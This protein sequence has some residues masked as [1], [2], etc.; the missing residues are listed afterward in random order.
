[1]FNFFIEEGNRNNNRYL[2]NGA[3]YNHIKNV[4][5]M[6]IGDEFLVSENNVSNLCKIVSFESECVIAEIVSEKF[7]D[8]SLPIKIYLFQGLPKSDKLELIIQKAV[9]LGVEEIIPVEMNRSIVKIDEKKKKSKTERWQSIA[10]SAAK[11]SKRT[12]IPKVNN[13]M[14]YKQALEYASKLD[15]FMIPYECKNEMK[16]T[17]NVLSKI[18][19]SM[20]VGILIGPEGGFEL[21]EIDSAVNCGGLTVSLGKRI[22]RTETA[23]ITAVGMCML[24]AEMNLNGEDE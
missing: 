6:K 8:T 11:Q 24:Y 21:N 16:S 9:E 5:R 3:D 7:Q 20:S 22:L 17:I 1:M 14:T 4:L 10:E 18:K 2:I 15:V 23:A 13:I 19:K 12:I